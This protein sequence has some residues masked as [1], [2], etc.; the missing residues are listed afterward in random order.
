M[1]NWK[2]ISIIIIISI[3]FIGWKI[4]SYKDE[5]TRLKLD[6]VKREQVLIDSLT[7]DKKLF[8]DK[9]LTNTEAIKKLYDKL[10]ESKKDSITLDEAKKLL[11]L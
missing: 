9:I 6:S 4:K 7:Q 11:G 3:L 2:V 8:E 10:K 5:I 1:K